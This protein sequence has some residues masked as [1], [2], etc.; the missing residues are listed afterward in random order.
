[1]DALELIKKE[2]FNLI[3]V[4]LKMPDIDG[5][6]LIERA[7]RLRYNLRFLIFT[8]GSMTVELEKKLK[9][10]KHVYGVIYKPFKIDQLLNKV[11]KILKV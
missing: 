11:E 3:L 8:G 1:M 7:K 10:D 4:D 9:E 5:F 2:T 6:E